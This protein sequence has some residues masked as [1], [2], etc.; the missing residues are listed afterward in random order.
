MLRH[1]HAAGGADAPEVVAPEVDEHEVLGRLLFA[2]AEL[3]LHALVILGVRPR[4]RVPR[5]GDMDTIP[6]DLDE[7]LRRRADQGA[8]RG[9][10]VDHVGARVD[11]P[12]CEVDVEGMGLERQGESPRDLDL[13][14]VPGDDV[15]ECAQDLILEL[16]TG[17]VGPRRS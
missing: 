2:S 9:G 4:R 17:Q 11:G 12:E 7:H 15:V 5:S 6:G 8:L 13:E 10:D 3:P 14:D 16:L 1:T